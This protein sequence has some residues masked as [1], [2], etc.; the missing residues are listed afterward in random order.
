MIDIIEFCGDRAAVK[1]TGKWGFIS[2]EI[3]RQEVKA[4]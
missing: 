1:Q 3:N 4:E 2:L